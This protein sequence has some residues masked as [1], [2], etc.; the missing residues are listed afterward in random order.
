MIIVTLRLTCSFSFHLW[1]VFY[2]WCYTAITHTDNKDIN[3]ECH[4]DIHLLPRITNV[5][6]F[7]SLSHKP[8]FSPEQVTRLTHWLS[9]PE[10]ALSLMH[11][12]HRSS[13][14][15]RVLEVSRIIFSSCVHQVTSID[16]SLLASSPQPN[17]RPRVRTGQPPLSHWIVG[18]GVTT[19]WAVLIQHKDGGR[20]HCIKE[21]LIPLSPSI[22]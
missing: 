14:L 2:T 9:A 5:L 6:L 1:F 13:L 11:V 15:S 21:S 12:T 22:P 3:C 4:L 17:H 7:V 19:R 18:T 10:A 8:L 16:F 20:L